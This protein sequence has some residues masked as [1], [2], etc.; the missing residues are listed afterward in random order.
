MINISTE[1]DAD[2][3]NNCSIMLFDNSGTISKVENKAKSNT[4]AVK[5]EQV[6]MT[7]FFI[8]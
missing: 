6:I 5:L 3:T 8:A 1:M 4:I 2:I 7:V